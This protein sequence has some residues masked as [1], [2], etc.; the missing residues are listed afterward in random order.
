MTAPDTKARAWRAT[1]NSRSRD[2]AREWIF[3]TE[4]FEFL[5]RPPK[6]DA[7]CADSSSP[8]PH[9]MDTI[10]FHRFQTY[11]LSQAADFHLRVWTEPTQVNGDLA[12]GYF[13][14]GACREAWRERA[15]G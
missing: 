2:S 9:S 5:Q 11:G 10:H 3:E 6:Q 13:V 14:A 7:G 8:A 12:S 15:S 4:V 1:H